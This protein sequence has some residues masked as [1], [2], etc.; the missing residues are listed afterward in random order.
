MV[1]A[2]GISSALAYMHIYQP[3]SESRTALQSV[4]CREQVYVAVLLTTPIIPALSEYL[5]HCVKYLESVLKPMA[6][7]GHG[8]VILNRKKFLHPSP[9]SVPSH[10]RTHIEV[11]IHNVVFNPDSVTVLL[12]YTTG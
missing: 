5:T 3:H 4:E 2:A 10:I 7:R 12:L 9:P 8:L 6:V 11:Y 1:N